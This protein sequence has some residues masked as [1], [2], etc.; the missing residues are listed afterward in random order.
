MAPPV[1]GRGI[2]ADGEPLIFSPHDF[3]RI[4][5]N[6]AI[7]SGPPPHIAQIICGHKII[8]TTMRLRVK[9]SRRT[10][11]S[12]SAA[13]RRDPA[14]NTA[15]R[16]TRNGTSPSPPSKRT[17]WPSSAHSPDPK[18][19]TAGAITAIAPMP[20]HENKCQP[21]ELTVSRA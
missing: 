16:P 3:R 21:C 20:N 14:G 15:P 1:W 11:P 7:M 6:D 2:G 17:F 9:R 10:A 13:E 12:S 19:A 8:Q 5:V 18:T 4:F